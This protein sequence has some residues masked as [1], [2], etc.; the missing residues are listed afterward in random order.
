MH[1]NTDVLERGKLEKLLSDKQTGR[2]PNNMFIY[3]RD[4]H[5]FLNNNLIKFL[6]LLILTL[7]LKILKTFSAYRAFKA[8]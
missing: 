7:Q 8:H 4:L 6:P 3:N 1:S 2:M 5:H